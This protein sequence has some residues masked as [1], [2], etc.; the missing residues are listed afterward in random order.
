MQRAPVDVAQATSYGES[1]VKF[2]LGTLV[3]TSTKR[4]R[5]EPP[6]NGGRG[7]PES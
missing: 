3:G 2:L 7:R 4:F 5:R 6:L 1:E